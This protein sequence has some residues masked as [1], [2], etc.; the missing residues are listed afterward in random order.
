VTWRSQLH[1]YKQGLCTQYMGWFSDNH[2]YHLDCPKILFF[3]LY[4]FAKYVFNCLSVLVH[5]YYIFLGDLQSNL[6]KFLECLILC[7]RKKPIRHEETKSQARTLI[8][9][10]FCG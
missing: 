4:V 9:L 5:Y 1:E 6:E 10:W 8:S 3:F 2:Q 7:C